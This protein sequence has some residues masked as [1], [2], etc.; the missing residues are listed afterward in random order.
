M[1]KKLIKLEVGVAEVEELGIK[2][3]S[4]FKSNYFK[5]KVKDGEV[6]SKEALK[7]IMVVKLRDEKKYLKDMMRKKNIMRE[8]INKELKKNSRP[9]RRM[10]QEF[11]NESA[12]TRVEYREK[13]RQKLDHL[14]G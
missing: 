14:K 4:K 11:R 3:H 7:S 8:E 6:V 12:K 2:I 5:N 13:Y 1:M 9:S 10:L